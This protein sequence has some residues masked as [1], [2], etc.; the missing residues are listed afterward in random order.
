MSKGN[1]A[2]VHRQ[3]NIQSATGR[4]D[5][6][7]KSKSSKDSQAKDRNATQAAPREYPQPPMPQQHLRKPGNEHALRPRPEYPAPD[8]AFLAASSCAS[9]ISGAILPILGGPTG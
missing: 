5:K 8:Y 6:R 4:A 2:T 9:Y 7:R 1:T 3:R